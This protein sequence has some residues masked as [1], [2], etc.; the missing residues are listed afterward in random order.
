MERTLVI[1]KPCTIQRGLIGEIISRFEKK[2]LCLVGMKMVW[3]TDEILSEHYAHLKE[4]PFFQRIK[5]AMSVC[6]V[7]V[8]CWEGVDAIQ[9]VRLMAGTTNG[10][11]AQPGTIRGD[12]SMS[13]QENIVHASD[14]PETAAIELKR[15]FVDSELFSYKRN[16]LLSIYANDEF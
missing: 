5:D 12:Y 9:V 3:L 7:I 6:P 11:N 14:S 1:L 15:F 13:V 10:R 4:K 2:G 16:D 8:C